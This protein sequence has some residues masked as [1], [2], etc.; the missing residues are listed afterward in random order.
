M[1]P[2]M[3][4]M[5]ELNDL[6]RERLAAGGVEV[7]MECYANSEWATGP[8]YAALRLNEERLGIIMKAAK[9]CA[10]NEG[11]NFIELSMGPSR[12][13]SDVNESSVDLS[14]RYWDMRVYKDAMHFHGMPKEGDD[15]VESR[16]I[17]LAAM[18]RALNAEPDS[19]AVPENM[20]WFGGAL[21]YGTSDVQGL[22][23][24]V[25]EDI[26]EIEACE[27][28][29]VMR[30]VISEMPAPDPTAAPKRNR[31]NDI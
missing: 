6:A 16:S 24:I 3:V 27:N 10:D 7:F 2:T 8:A 17:D 23:D 9:A 5:P 13:Q 28:A 29:R 4:G 19:E 18:L 30:C 14:I 11:W 1:I 26:P 21:L 15:S 25:A 31:R 22:L 12:T 20:V